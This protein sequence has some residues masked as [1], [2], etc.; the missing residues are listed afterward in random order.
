MTERGTVGIT[1]GNLTAVDPEVTAGTRSNTQLVY[2]LEALP[3]YGTLTLNGELLGVGSI[4]TQDG[5]LNSRLVY[6][7]KATGA[8]QN[9]ADSFLVS[10]NDGATPQSFSSANISTVTIAVTPVNQPPVLTTAGGSVYEGVPAGAPESSIG[11]FIVANAG[12]DPGDTLT[13]QL[14]SLPQHGALIFT[15]TLTING[16]TRT[17]TGQ[18]L[19]TYVIPGGAQLDLGSDTVLI[20]QDQLSGL[21]YAHNGTEPSA[22]PTDSFNVVVKGADGA[23]GDLLT[24]ADNF[25]VTLTTGMLNVTDSDSP[26]SSITFAVVDSPSYGYSLSRSAWPRGPAPPPRAIS[27]R[28]GR[29]R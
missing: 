19:A 28:P 21:H 23:D 7:H 25:R 14:T 16:V 26:P 20:A 1:A 5:V 2:R 4:F 13:I 17:L 12:G 15:G 8:D 29:R 3:V 24:S 11:N 22:A 6:T 18:D 27:S 10:V 9:T